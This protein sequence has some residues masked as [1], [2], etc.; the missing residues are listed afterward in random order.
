MKKWIYLLFFGLAVVVVAATAG[1]SLDG[2]SHYSLTGKKVSEEYKVVI[3]GK[4]MEGALIEGNLYVPL[5]PM[6]KELDVGFTVDSPNKVITV[7]E[8]S[9]APP[10]KFMEKNASELRALQ[11][12]LE[13]ETLP[14]L[15]KRRKQISAKMTERFQAGDKEGYEAETRR[16][17]E[18]KAEMARRTEELRLVKEA[19]IAKSRK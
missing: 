13:N 9:P 1:C 14:S 19:L 16:L 17:V 8:E 12:T 10:N 18:C 4:P 3:N 5:R 2:Q 6:L 15:K 11:R 7:G